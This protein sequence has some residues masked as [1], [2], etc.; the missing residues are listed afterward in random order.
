M[1]SSRPLGLFKFIY[2]TSFFTLSFMY[3]FFATGTP[4]ISDT[5]PVLTRF[6]VWRKHSNYTCRTM[7]QR[8]VCIFGVIDLPAL[9][10]D[11]RV[12]LFLNKIHLT[13][14]PLILDCLE[15]YY[16]NRTQAELRGP[17]SLNITRYSEYSFVWNHNPS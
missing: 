11:E 13:Y 14:Q 1:R 2:F 5:N 10:F 16:F 12:E 4:E 9:K 7:H 17:T 3:L 8:G 15:E 6:V